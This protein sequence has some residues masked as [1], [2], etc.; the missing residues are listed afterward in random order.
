MTTSN[1]IIQPQAIPDE[2]EG[3]FSSSFAPSLKTTL[4]QDSSFSSFSSS[5]FPSYSPSLMK[6]ALS[7]PEDEDKEE[8]H[9]PSFSPSL[10]TSL[11]HP[12]PDKD[13]HT[14]SFSASTNTTLEKYSDVNKDSHTP[15]Y[16][17]SLQTKSPQG[18]FEYS[19]N[20]SVS[21][22]M[23]T[24]P[25][26]E[27]PVARKES[28]SPSTIPSLTKTQQSFTPSAIPMSLPTTVRPTIFLEFPT[29]PP[30]QN[31]YDDLKISLVIVS[32]PMLI[33]AG[34]F[35]WRWYHHRRFVNNFRDFETQA[36]S[37]NI[38]DRDIL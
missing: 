9:I 25:P 8:S 34:C 33:I 15:S 13:S 26:Q 1:E 29:Q 21:P 30:S 24:T 4:E 31:E 32:A 10:K 17:P 16:S 20:T 38:A 11:I 37:P 28:Y 23:Q 6:T 2:S 5:N 18:S 35:V 12:D 7:F 36:F 27:S 3:S 22:S 14:P 19:Y